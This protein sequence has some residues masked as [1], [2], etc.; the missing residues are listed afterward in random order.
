MSVFV[1]VGLEP[2]QGAG[3]GR[4]RPAIFKA[5]RESGGKLATGKDKTSSSSSSSSSSS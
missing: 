2:V 3:G 5:A 1:A 4:E